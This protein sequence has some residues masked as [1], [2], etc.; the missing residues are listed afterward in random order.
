MMQKKKGKYTRRM[1]LH[2]DTETAALLERMAISEKTTRSEIIRRMLK[3]GAQATGFQE[4]DAQ[5]Q[6]RVTASVREIIKPYIERLAAISAKS[7]QISGASFFL[8]AYVF[9]LLFPEDR[10]TQIIRAAVK[11]H[12]AGAEFAKLKGSR[13]LNDFLQ[14]TLF[15]KEDFHTDRKKE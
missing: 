15:T 7:A 2:C 5:L 10:Q 11:A 8:D 13:E 1:C 6:A 14:D 3:K 9:S 4:D 12:R